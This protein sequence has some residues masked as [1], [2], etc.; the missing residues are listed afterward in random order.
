M[1][2]PRTD[3]S[4]DR[5]RIEAVPHGARR[6]TGCLED[7]DPGVDLAQA[8][9]GHDQHAIGQQRAQP[10]GMSVEGRELGAGHGGDEVIARRV[11]EQDPF[12]HTPI[13]PSQQPAT[14][15]QARSGHALSQPQEHGIKAGQAQRLAGEL[16]HLAGHIGLPAAL[17]DQPV[18]DPDVVEEAGLERALGRRCRTRISS[19]PS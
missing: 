11:H 10:G 9:T 6:R 19:Y 14:R 1:A 16:A 3:T 4:Y 15:G 12:A 5:G 18:G 13:L 7:R 17:D 2:P 8:R